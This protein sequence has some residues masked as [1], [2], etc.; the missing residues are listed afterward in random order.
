MNIVNSGT[1]NTSFE[2]KAPHLLT[3]QDIICLKLLYIYH[4]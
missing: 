1:N 3:E 4:N 2:A